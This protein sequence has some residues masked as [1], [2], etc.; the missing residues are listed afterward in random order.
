MC[1]GVVGQ[2]RIVSRLS[3]YTGVKKLGCVR[4][5]VRARVRINYN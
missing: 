3:D 1:V 4:A 2:G 5:C